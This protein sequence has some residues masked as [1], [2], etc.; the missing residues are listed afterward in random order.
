MSFSPLQITHNQ[1]VPGAGW[2]LADPLRCHPLCANPERMVTCQKLRR[3][4]CFIRVSTHLLNTFQGPGWMWIGSHTLGQTGS[5]IMSALCLPAHTQSC[6]KAADSSSQYMGTH[7]LTLG[8]TGSAPHS[9]GTLQ[10]HCPFAQDYTNTV[11]GSPKRDER[12]EGSTF[13]LALKT[14]WAQSLYHTQQGASF[15]SL[16][17][18]KKPT[19]G[20]VDFLSATNL[21]LGRLADDNNSTRYENVLLLMNSSKTLWDFFFLKQLS[22]TMSIIKWPQMKHLSADCWKPEYCKDKKELA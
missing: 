9:K 8:K 6:D 17:K 3:N 22:L 7:S 14:G 20:L 11:Q 12:A 2:K 15:I 5:P 19:K 4:S 18:K 1:I 10:S 21:T 13:Q 16:Q